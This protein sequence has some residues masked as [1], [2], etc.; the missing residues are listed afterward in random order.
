MANQFARRLKPRDDGAEAAAPAGRSGPGGR[1]GAAGIDLSQFI[2][3]LP[4]ISLA[5]LK[6]GSAI[7]LTGTPQADTAHLTAITIV[8][9]IEPIVTASA[10]SVQDLLAG[11]NPGGG[12][13][14]GGEQ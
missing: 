8:A 11:W 5:D 6:T 3:R 10:S 4:A 9:G 13:G 2:D 1:G 12:E 7:I 14:G